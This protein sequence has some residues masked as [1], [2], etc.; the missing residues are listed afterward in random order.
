MATR[1][2]KPLPC[3]IRTAQS[4]N[5][6]EFGLLC[7]YLANQ[8][9]DCIYGYLEMDE[10]LDHRE[11]YF[12]IKNAKAEVDTA[13]WNLGLFRLR[14]PH[15]TREDMEAREILAPLLSLAAS[16]D[17]SQTHV[18]LVIKYQG[19]LPIP[20]NSG[21]LGVEAHR[22]LWWRRNLYDLEDESQLHNR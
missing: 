18:A 5:V 3:P 21:P 17:W 8:A 22:D 20:V 19:S 13:I 10:D 11:R 1:I 14:Y 9:L 12:Y 7:T 6:D 4:L 2:L 16:S 15:A